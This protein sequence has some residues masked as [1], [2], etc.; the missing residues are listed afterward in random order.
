MALL[1]CQELKKESAVHE[2]M[3]MMM[4]MTVKK[5]SIKA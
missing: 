3:M 1:Y 4:I 5:N 2:M